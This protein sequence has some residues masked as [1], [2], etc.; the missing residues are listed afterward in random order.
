M[1]C[2]LMSVSCGWFTKPVGVLLPASYQRC[3]H[4]SC[5]FFARPDVFRAQ[6]LR[7]P[8]HAEHVV[9]AEVAVAAKVG[10]THAHAYPS[11]D[12]KAP[13][14]PRSNCI[15]ASGFGNATWSTRRC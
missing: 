14:R 11:A 2:L 8:Q 7:V 10:P 4:I 12:S 9:R 5:P 13:Y 15:F 6:V 1:Q 3:C